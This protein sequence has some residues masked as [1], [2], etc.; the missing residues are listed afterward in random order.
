MKFAVV[1]ALFLGVLALSVDCTTANRSLLFGVG[2]PPVNANPPPDLSSLIST[3]KRWNLE[4]NIAWNRFPETADALWAATRLEYV[5]GNCKITGIA[6]ACV[7][8]SVCECFYCVLYSQ[9][10]SRPN[11]AT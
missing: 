10:P 6:L 8:F 4:C 5:G 7:A 2:V 3:M 9:V 11:W 1:L